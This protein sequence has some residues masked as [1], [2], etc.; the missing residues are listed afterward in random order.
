MPPPGLQR[1]EAIAEQRHACDDNWH[2]AN[3][4][5]GVHSICA[6]V[7]GD[8]GRPEVD[9]RARVQHQRHLEFQVR[10]RLDV[11]AERLRRLGGPTEQ[12][13]RLRQGHRG[14]QRVTRLAEFAGAVQITVEPAHCQALAD[15]KQ[16]DRHQLRLQEREPAP[17]PCVQ[18]HP[19]EEAR[20]V[21]EGKPTIHSCLAV[22]VRLQVAMG[23]TDGDGACHAQALDSPAIRNEQDVDA[24]HEQ[25]VDVRLLVVP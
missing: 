18:A 24:R 4:D 8:Q 3:A 22:L 17:P 16:V 19:Q 21:Q 5:C 20:H 15:R 23:I 2:C 9:R 13:A 14:S 6:Q 7:A 10:L 25:S 1:I 11:D 12:H